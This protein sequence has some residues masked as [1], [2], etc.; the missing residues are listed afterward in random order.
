MFIDGRNQEMPESMIL[1][2][3][4]RAGRQEYNTSGYVY[5]LTQKDKVVS[6]IYNFY[7]FLLIDYVQYPCTLRSFFYWG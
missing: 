7:F 5:I 3:M 6:N 4:G 2:M 1:Q